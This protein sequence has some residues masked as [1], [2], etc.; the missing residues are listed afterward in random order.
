MSTPSV[1]RV[2]SRRRRLSCGA[3]APVRACARDGRAG[4]RRSARARPGRWCRPREHVAV[5]DLQQ[6]L[7]G[8]D[9]EWQV[10]A[11]R[12]DRAVRE[13]A[14]ARGDHRHHALGLQ[15][16]ELGRR[17]V[18]GDEDVAGEAFHGRGAAMQRGVD[19]ADDL[20][21]V[22][23]AAA[24]VRIVH[25]LEDVRDAV[26]LQAQCVV[27]GEAAHAD[28]VVEALQQFGV[29]EEQCVQVE[30]FADFLRERAMQAHAQH[31]HFLAHDIDGGVQAIEFDVDRL[32]GDAF[33]ADVQHM[34]QPD[35]GAAERAAAR[36]PMPGQD[37]PHQ[38]PSS[39]RR[40]NSS[41]TAAAASA[42][43]SPST[44]SVTGVPWP[45]ASS[46]TPMM[47][48]AFTSRPFAA[49]VAPLR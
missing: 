43:S 35:P 39:N 37:L 46:I 14:A 34:R 11:A 33:F 40:S 24:Q 32:G 12:E 23:D 19:A 42:S 2:G 20:V 36:G 13:R 16:R 38:P 10:Q 9:D 6:R 30:E 29:V 22:V 8:T 31:A 7:R 18:V 28:Q 47:L 4:R 27:R 44:R 48:L 15:L 5:V 17:D 49:S 41:E 3:R 26:A 45:A 1:V 25:V 21:D